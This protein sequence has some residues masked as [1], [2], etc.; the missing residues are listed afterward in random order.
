MI[1]LLH[2]V[3]RPKLPVIGF[4]TEIRASSSGS[5]NTETEVCSSAAPEVKRLYLPTIVPFPFR[6]V[7]GII[8]LA[9]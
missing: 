8:G 4:G 9:M 6:N 1:H 5:F 3:L 7:G 2:S